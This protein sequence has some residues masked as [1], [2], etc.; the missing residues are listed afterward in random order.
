MGY[1]NRGKQEEAR[2]YE[3]AA[4]QYRRT[5]DR[6]GNEVNAIQPFEKEMLL[7]ALEN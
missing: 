3:Q 2:I 1:S 7:H 6:N 4:E 5:L